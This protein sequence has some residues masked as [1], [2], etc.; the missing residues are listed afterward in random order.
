MSGGVENPF[1]CQMKHKFEPEFE[2]QFDGYNV[3]YKLQFNDDTGR[4]IPGVSSFYPHDDDDND[5]NDNDEDYDY[6]E[7]PAKTFSEAMVRAY[8][9]GKLVRIPDILV[10]SMIFI[11]NQY[12][13]LT[14]GCNSFLTTSFLLFDSCACIHTHPH[15]VRPQLFEYRGV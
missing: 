7:T 6:E 2:T 12:F 1:F 4:K 10:D 8:D 13:M 5:D 11:V 14:V 3:T 15:P 9:T